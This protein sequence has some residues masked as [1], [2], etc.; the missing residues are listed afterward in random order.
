MWRSREEKSRQC[1][2]GV[3]HR[4]PVNLYYLLREASVRLAFAESPTLGAKPRAKP[5]SL[6]LSATLSQ[7]GMQGSQSYTLHP[8]LIAGCSLGSAWDAG[9][10]TVIPVSLTVIV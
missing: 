6:R 8:R 7:S 9:C 5:P 10:M 3:G 4:Y 2:V 1:V